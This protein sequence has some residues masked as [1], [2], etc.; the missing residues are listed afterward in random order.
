M[1]KCPRRC[2]RKRKKPPPVKVCARSLEN[3]AWS[4]GK[5][6]EIEGVTALHKVLQQSNG[7][8]QMRQCHLSSLAKC[9]FEV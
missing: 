6:D 5:H 4:K 9:S 2:C 8:G 7:P 3:F 1:C